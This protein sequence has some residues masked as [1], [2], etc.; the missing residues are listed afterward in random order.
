MDAPL[1]VLDIRQHQKLLFWRRGIWLGGTALVL[2]I[3]VIPV[4]VLWQVYSLAGQNFAAHAASK[5]AQSK[6]LAVAHTLIQCNWVLVALAVIG[7]SVSLYKYAK[8]RKTV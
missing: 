6:K 3:F 7:L 4:V 1:S 5:A 8:L 2:G